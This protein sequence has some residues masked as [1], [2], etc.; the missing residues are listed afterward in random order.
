MKNVYAFFFFLLLYQT[1]SFASDRKK[2][3]TGDFYHTEKEKK[4]YKHA[5]GFD[6]LP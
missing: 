1:H 4:K 2:A 5:K 3:V 6:R